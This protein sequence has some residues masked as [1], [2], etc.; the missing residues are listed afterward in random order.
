MRLLLYLYPSVHLYSLSWFTQIIQGNSL[1]VFLMQARLGPAVFTCFAVC[2]KQLQ[3]LEVAKICLFFFFFLNGQSRVFTSKGI[4]C[5]F[6]YSEHLVWPTHLD[7]LL[8]FY[9]S[10]FKCFQ[11]CTCHTYNVDLSTYYILLSTIRFTCLEVEGRV[12]KAGWPQKPGTTVRD[13]VSTSVSPKPLN[14]FNE[15]L[16]HFHAVFVATKLNILLV[17]TDAGEPKHDLSLILTKFCHCRRQTGLVFRALTVLTL[18]FKRHP[19][20]NHIKV[21]CQLR[22]ALRQRCCLWHVGE[23]MERSLLLLSAQRLHVPVILFLL[24]K[25]NLRHERHIFMA[26]VLLLCGPLMVSLPGRCSWH[27][28]SSASSV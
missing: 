25:A 23:K 6:V 28:L 26:A 1:P 10:P 12:G 11:L 4:W 16:E 18:S 3:S 24:I 8:F 7:K 22:V 14:I 9:L 17:A 21:E 13:C 5:S 20:R 15:M 27:F 19:A 2:I